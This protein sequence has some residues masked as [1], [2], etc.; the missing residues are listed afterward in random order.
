MHKTLPLWRAEHVNSTRLLD[1][2]G[3]QLEVFHAGGVPRYELMLD[4]MYYMT[5]YSDVLHH[6]KED[7]AFAE[8]KARN[9]EIA[10]QVDAL[11]E[12]SEEHT[13][14]LQSLTN[15]VCR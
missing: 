3:D 8:I 10:P 2:L 6:P 13:S 14:E 15:L 4:I 1:L 11:I 7:L 5:H 9:K 12:R